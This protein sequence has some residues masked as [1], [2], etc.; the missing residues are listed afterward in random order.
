MPQTI[1]RTSTSSLISAAARPAAKPAK[2]VGRGESYD[3]D[4]QEF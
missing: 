4:W 1:S 2:A 3:K